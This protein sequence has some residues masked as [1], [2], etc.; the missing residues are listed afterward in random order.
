[1][2]KARAGQWADT[3]LLRK[4]YINSHLQK[5]GRGNHRCVWRGE[6]EA[7]LEEEAHLFSTSSFVTTTHTYFEILSNEGAEGGEATHTKA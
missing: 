3:L 5:Q 2:T 6:L 7:V 1:M 4:K